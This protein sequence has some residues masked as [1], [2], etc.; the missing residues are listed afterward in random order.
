MGKG[1]KRSKKGKI[2]SK[3]YGTKRNKKKRADSYIKI[4]DLKYWSIER[5]FAFIGNFDYTVNIQFKNDSDG[6]RKYGMNITGLLIYSKEERK[7]LKSKI[8][9][10]IKNETDGNIRFDIVLK[11]GL[12]EQLITELYK[13]GFNNS[14][15]L[16]V[17]F[18]PYKSNKT[19]FNKGQKKLEDP[20]V[21]EVNH[22]ISNKEAYYMKYNLYKTRTDG[23]D[24]I[25]DDEKLEIMALQ[26]ALNIKEQNSK[27]LHDQLVNNRKTEFEFK[28]EE[29]KYYLEEIE[30]IS[31]NVFKNK[32]LQVKSIVDSEFRIAGIDPD[33]ALQMIN[34]LGIYSGLLQIGT[35][36]QEKIV[37]YSTTPKIVLDFKGF[38]HIAF[39]HSNVLNIGKNNKDKSRIPYSLVEI[40][41]L[42]SSCLQSVE[43]EIELHYKKHPEKRFSKFGN[44]LIRFN[45]NDYV[46]QIN[47][48]GIIETFYNQN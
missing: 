32:F 35:F 38:L 17:C 46:V 31:D 41:R 11:K 15:I 27:Y 33:D 34:Y 39:R 6:F 22:K 5:L 23:N 21:I 3:T 4:S 44:E 13:I 48:Q 28:L 19:Y 7:I 45:G 1:D 12:S 43:E 18:I 14:D 9:S 29:I 26:K 2:R 47:P 42:V 10:G 30:M 16:T 40:D 20:L 25:T 8:N 36:Y 37:L 24:F